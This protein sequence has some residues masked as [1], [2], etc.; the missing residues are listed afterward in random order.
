MT[1]LHRNDR[2]RKL[3]ISYDMYLE[4]KFLLNKYGRYI[5]FNKNKDISSFQFPAALILWLKR[6]ILCHFKLLF[7]ATG[8]RIMN[9]YSKMASALI[10]H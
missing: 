2:F 3:P 1:S 5:N 4:L 7:S 10:T 9:T 6:H 8:P